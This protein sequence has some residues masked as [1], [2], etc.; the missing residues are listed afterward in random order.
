MKKFKVLALCANDADATSFYRGLT[1]LAV[2]EK[3]MEGRFEVIHHWGP[4]HFNLNRLRLIDAIF[5]QRPCADF[6]VSLM[7]MARAAGIPTWVDMDDDVFHIPEANPI[8]HIYKAQGTIN[9]A[10]SAFQLAS[11]ITT[12]TEALREVLLGFNKNVVVIPNAFDDGLF[13]GSKKVPVEKKGKKTVFWRGST[14]HDDDMLSI[15]GSLKE[16]V[17][18]DWTFVFAGHLP[19]VI[20]RELPEGSW[21]H[22]P[23][24]NNLIDYFNF[25]SQLQ[26]DIAIVPLV[27]VP[28]NRAKSNIAWIEASFGGAAVIAPNWDEWRK[29][30]MYTYDSKE[31]FHRTLKDLMDGNGDTRAANHESWRYI[32]ENLLLTKVN[33]ERMAVVD[34]IMGMVHK[35]V[36]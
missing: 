12:T 8:G 35:K 4:F 23:W 28:F 13:L 30:G 33:I 27:D 29:P 16:H 17:R 11:V 7:E 9:H 32:F 22:A 21:Y 36:Q 34:E 25:I 31:E 15:A 14:T 5:I 10:A 1:P 2:L 19:W 26:P 18:D 6:H 24:K 20:T 3:Q